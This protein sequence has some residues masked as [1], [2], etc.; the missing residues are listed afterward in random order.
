MTLEHI[1]GMPIEESLLPLAATAS[2]AVVALRAA[3]L[4]LRHRRGRQAPRAF[5]VRGRRRR[6]EVSGSSGREGRGP[7]PDAV[8][9]Q[10]TVDAGHECERACGGFHP[11]ALRWDGTP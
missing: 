7:A 2:A 9:P 10:A 1:A 4:R 8:A 3:L 11:S 5:G 6:A